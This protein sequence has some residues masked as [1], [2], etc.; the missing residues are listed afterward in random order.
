MRPLFAVLCGNDF[1]PV[2]YFDAYLPCDIGLNL[3]GPWWKKRNAKFNGIIKWLATFGNNVIQAVN[4]VIALVPQGQQNEAG[5][6]LRLSVSTYSLDITDTTF[7]KALNLR[8]SYTPQHLEY[9]QEGPSVGDAVQRLLQ[10]DGGGG[11]VEQFSMMREW[12]KTLVQSF[13]S[14]SFS[15]YICGAVYTTANLFSDGLEDYEHQRTAASLTGIPI[16]QVAYGIFAYI[17]RS[18]LE[19]VPGLRRNPPFLTEFHRTQTNEMR[20]FDVPWLHYTGFSGTIPLSFLQEHFRLPSKPQSMSPEIYGAA[21]VFSIWRRL[22]RREGLFVDNAVGLAVATTY[23]AVSHSPPAARQ[24]LVDTMRS[25][26]NSMN[27]GNPSIKLLDFGI[28]HDMAEIKNIYS[29]LASLTHL[30]GCVC[31]EGADNIVLPE[32]T[33]FFASGHFIHQLGKLLGTRPANLRLQE[34]IKW[35]RQ[36]CVDFPH[37]VLSEIVDWIDQPH[38]TGQGMPMEDLPQVQLSVVSIAD[39]L[40]E[41]LQQVHI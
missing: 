20:P 22:T 26:I 31:L 24:G 4:E 16:R 5:G 21:V 10:E 8:A 7:L 39:L 14:G 19:E 35:G 25:V 17:E 1:I 30:L 36:L 6:Y 18:R 34:A 11:A 15:P 2:G 23:L 41:A 9:Q 33:G 27:R 29:N 32:F 12:P 40:A 37:T 13:R 28:L 3:Q 38:P